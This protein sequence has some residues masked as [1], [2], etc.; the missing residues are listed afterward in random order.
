MLTGFS[1][2]NTDVQ[3]DLFNYERKKCQE[4]DEQQ[5]LSAGNDLDTRLSV[6]LMS[7]CWPYLYNCE[8]QFHG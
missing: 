3:L 6:E 7:E 4:E 1:E 8:I 2:I 5:L